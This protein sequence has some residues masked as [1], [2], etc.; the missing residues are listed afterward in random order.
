M[1]VADLCREH[2]IS[3]ATFYDWRSKYGGMDGAILSEMSRRQAQPTRWLKKMH[4]EMAMQNERLKDAFG[5]SRKAI[6]STRDAQGGCSELGR[7]EIAASDFPTKG[8]PVELASRAFGI[9]ETCYWY[10]AK[11]LDET[12]EIADWLVRLAK[13]EKTRR[14]G[15]GFCD[16][17]LRNVKGFSWNHKRVRHIYCELELNHRIKPRKRL[18]REMPEPLAVPELPNEM[19]SMDFMADQLGDGQ[20]F[21]SLNVLDAVNREGLAIEGTSPC[22]Q[23]ASCACSPSATV[24]QTGQIA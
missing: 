17:F 15:I 16:L 7:K 1:P 18:S 12:A 14:W 21:R 5:K 3:N 4:A 9:S 10:E 23:R 8:V 22:Q 11:L 19:W 24:R 6:S 2:G 20:S 13:F